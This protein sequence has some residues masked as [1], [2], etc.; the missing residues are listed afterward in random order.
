M[1]PPKRFDI[2]PHLTG[3]C[4][5]GLDAFKFCKFFFKQQYKGGGIQYRTVCCTETRFY[6]HQFGFRAISSLMAPLLV[7]PPSSDSLKRSTFFTIV[8]HKHYRY[9]YLAISYHCDMEVAQYMYGCKRL[10]SR[11]SVSE[12][13]QDCKIFKMCSHLDGSMCS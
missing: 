2:F 12:K 6:F 5:E 11:C 4:S 10:F 13:T 9:L 3:R 8:Q 1:I 7:W